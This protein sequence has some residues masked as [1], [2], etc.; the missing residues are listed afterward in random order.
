MKRFLTISL[1]F[2]LFPAVRSSH[3][4]NKPHARS[5]K[6]RIVVWTNEDVERLKDRDLI[7]VVGQVQEEPAADVLPPET[8]P[9]DSAQDPA[10]YAEQAAKL[11]D[12]LERRQ[13]HLGDYRQAIEDAQS[14]RNT[15]S[16]VNLTEEDTAITLEDGIEVLQERVNETQSEL[17]D[18]EDLARRNDIE[19]GALRGQ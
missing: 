19:P 6:E 11:R 10:W 5:G 12:E 9:Y 15:T 7:S 17:D 18:L 16:G 3:A 2:V 13:A 14:L 1:A 4:A 8:A